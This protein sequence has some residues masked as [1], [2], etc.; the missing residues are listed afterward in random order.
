MNG[1][2]LLRSGDLAMVL[3][4]CCVHG[5]LDHVVLS[6]VTAWCANMSSGCVM[7][8]HSADRLEYVLLAALLRDICFSH[9]SDEAVV[10]ALAGKR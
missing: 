4:L 2:V 5:P 3:V 9:C 1:V 10:C 8:V 7:K 6:L